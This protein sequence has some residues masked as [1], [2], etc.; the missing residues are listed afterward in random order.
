[1]ANLP[2]LVDTTWLAAHLHDADLRV[3]DSTTNVIREPGRSDKVIAERAK[4][5]EGHIPGAQFVDLQADLSDND[6]PLHFTAPPAASFARA[7]ERFGIGEGTR[8]VIYST[9]NVWWAT[10]V[11]WLF[12]LFGFDDV[13]LLDGG[14]KAWTDEKRSI[15]TGPGRQHARAHFI[16]HPPRPLVA[17]KF[18]V[19]A[20]IE[21]GDTCIINAL[22]P[23]LH[24]G[25]GPSPYGRPGHVKRSVNVPG[26]SLVDPATGRFLPRPQIERLF[27]D[28]GASAGKK[29]ITYCG[30]GITASATAFALALIGEPNAQVYDA[31]LQEWAPDD[32]LPMEVG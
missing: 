11:W 8:V 15:E 3:L 6:S 29:V 27:H 17:D 13:A 23:S 31:S 2:L 7:V 16:V 30:G 22:A 4:F 10:R 1:M 25:A 12:R 24:V 21:K 5:E 9:G 18:D 26:L 20:A 32:S 28:A 19:L 14:W